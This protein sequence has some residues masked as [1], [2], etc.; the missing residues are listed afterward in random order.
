MIVQTW[1]LRYS[2]EMFVE[3]IGR[4]AMI[5]FENPSLKKQN[6]TISEKINAFITIWHLGDQSILALHKEERSMAACNAD[7]SLCC[8]L[9]TTILVHID[10]ECFIFIWF[11]SSSLSS[12]LF[13]YSC[14]RLTIVAYSPCFTTTTTT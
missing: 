9:F 3:S 10:S 1:M 7:G 12:F 13:A 4:I 11:H 8:C 2:Y 5:V 6:S 14:A